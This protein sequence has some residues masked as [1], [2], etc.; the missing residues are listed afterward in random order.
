MSSWV[1]NLKPGDKEYE[2]L[3]RS[4]DRWDLVEPLV[5]NERTGNL[6]GGNQRLKI[7]KARGDTE[8]DVSV[9]NLS[10]IDEKALNIALNK[11]QGD[12]HFTP[13]ADLLTELDTGAFDLILTGF[14]TDELERIMNYAP[15]GEVQEDE[16]PEPPG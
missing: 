15:A 16:V 5:W 14:D 10:E 6:V 11:I 1:F 13:L 12:W 8:V 4:R 9:V 3:R 2:K 7:L